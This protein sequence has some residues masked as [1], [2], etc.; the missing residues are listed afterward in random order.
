LKLFGVDAGL[1]KDPPIP[2]ANRIKMSPRKNRGESPLKKKPGSD[3]RKIEE[4]DDGS[5]L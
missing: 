3:L 2:S 4:N 5:L 1:I